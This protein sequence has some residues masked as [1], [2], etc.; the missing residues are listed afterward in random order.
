MIYVTKVGSRP[1]A[2]VFSGA[3]RRIGF[4]SI[5]ADRRMAFDAYV[6]LCEDDDAVLAL[7]DEVRCQPTASIVH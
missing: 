5:A 3:Q 2:P 7:L 1:R 4:S 6:A